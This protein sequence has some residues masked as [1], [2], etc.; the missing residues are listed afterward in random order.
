MILLTSTEY[1][2]SHSGLNDNT[3]DKM[4]IPALER[5]QDIELCEALG[6]C[7]VQSLKDKIADES[8]ND[9]DNILYKTLI[10]NYVQ[11]YLTYTVLANLTLEI[12]Q[13][14]GNGG[15]DTIT[16][17]H[18]QTLSFDERGQYKDYW[19]HQADAYKIRMQKFLKNNS[20]AF[21]EW[22]ACCKSKD[23][24]SSACSVWLGGTRGK[25]IFKDDCCKR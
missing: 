23:D 5:A 20:T 14:I 15:I 10:D 18:R 12:G 13:V 17:E 25:I 3:Y 8:I 6:D 22:L 1:I 21:P 19:L 4:I 16:D 11:Q 24:L 9:P 2:K 7:L